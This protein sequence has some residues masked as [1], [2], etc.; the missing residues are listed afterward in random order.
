MTEAPAQ[1]TALYDLFEFFERF[2][3]PRI[4]K[5]TQVKERD[6]VACFQGEGKKPVSVGTVVHVGTT[7]LCKGHEDGEAGE[8]YV[9]PFSKARYNKK[10]PLNGFIL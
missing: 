2:D 7:P 9:L 6:V 5:F 8:L 1:E 10:K 4:Q 3:V